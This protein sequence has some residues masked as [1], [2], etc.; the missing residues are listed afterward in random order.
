MESAIIELQIKGLTKEE[1]LRYQEILH[2]LIQC[3]GLSG[4]KGGRTIIHFDG[5]GIFQG[6]E[7]DYWPF[8]RRKKT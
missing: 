7:L 8:R 4:V 3:G 2:A 6:I 1:T 5:E